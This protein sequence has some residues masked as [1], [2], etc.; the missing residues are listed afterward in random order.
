MMLAGSWSR[1]H[2]PSWGVAES[3]LLTRALLV[4]RDGPVIGPS[5][6]HSWTCAERRAR[7]RAIRA[8]FEDLCGDT[9]PTL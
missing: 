7:D 6:P 2:W 5:E 4:R 1:R 3:G 8:T 9:T